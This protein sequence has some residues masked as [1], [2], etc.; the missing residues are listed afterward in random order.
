MDKARTRAHNAVLANVKL[1]NRLAENAGLAPVYEGTVSQER[2][3]RREVADAVM[4]YIAS[5]IEDRA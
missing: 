5:V 1:L 2:P 3:Y 4:A